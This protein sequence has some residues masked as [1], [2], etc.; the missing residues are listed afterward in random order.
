MIRYALRGL[1]RNPMFTAIALLTL[2][3]G[4]GANTAIFSVVN[5]VLLKPL[6]YPRP[7]ELVGVWQT[8]PG[9]AGLANFSSGLRLSLSMYLTYVEQNRAF[10]AFGVWAPNSFSVKGVAEPEQVRAVIVTDGTLQALSVPPPLGHGLGPDDYKLE[11]PET[12]MLG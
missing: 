6:P 9:A 5:S 11:A 8:A 3:I 10:Q 2:A 12:V 1:R 4:I 7:E